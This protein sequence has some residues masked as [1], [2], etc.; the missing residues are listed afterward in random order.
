MNLSVSVCYTILLADY[1]VLRRPSPAHQSHCMAVCVHVIA[2]D[3][4]VTA[5]REMMMTCVDQHHCRTLEVLTSD[6]T[7]A[8]TTEQCVLLGH[9]DHRPVYHTNTTHH[10]RDSTA[11]YATDSTHNTSQQRQHSMPLPV[12]TTHHSRDTTA[13]PVHTAHHS[14]DSTVC[15]CQY[16]QHI[17]AETPQHSTPLP[18]HTAHHSNTSS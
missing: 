13:Q 7:T 18:V 11:Q 16:T 1:A 17:T 5:D 2:D 14:R 3:V 4:Y 8:R 6:L 9:D 12:H 10:S 15:H